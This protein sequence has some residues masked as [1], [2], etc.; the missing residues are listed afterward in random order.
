LKEPMLKNIL[1]SISSAFLLVLSFPQFDL[2]F[3]AWIAL[4]PLLAVLATSGPKR[5]F[6]F[7]LLCGIIFFSGIFHWILEVP[8]YRLLHHGILGLYLGFY[9]GLFGLAF[10]GVCVRLGLTTALIA[11][12]FFWV[13][14]EFLRSNLWFLALPWGLLAHSQHHHPVFIQTAS[15]TGT[16]GV[17]FLIVLVNSALTAVGDGVLSRFKNHATAFDRTPFPKARTWAVAIAGGIWIISLIYSQVMISRPFDGQAA[18]VAVVQPNIP[19]NKKWNRKYA[20]F[21]MQTYADLT[22]HAAAEQ[23][24]LIIWPESATPAAINQNMKVKRQV[25]HIVRSAETYLLL[26][27]CEQQ[28]FGQRRSK[29]IIYKNSAFLISAKNRPAKRQRY[30]KI[31]LLPFGEYLPL[32]KTIPWSMINVPDIE[33]SVPGNKYTVFEHPAFRFGVTIC[34][35]NIFPEMVRQYVLRGAE[36]IVNITNEAWFGKTAAP[37]QFVSMSVFRAVENR[38]YVARSA[39][40][41]ISCL[42]DPYGRIVDRVRN[43]RG[44]D[45]FVRGNLIGYV[46]PMTSKTFYTRYGDWPVWVCTVFSVVFILLALFKGSRFKGSEVQG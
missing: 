15:V 39:N 5:G 21:I 27:S 35:E 28:K 33:R 16:Y 31:R 2:S 42:I 3:L 26:G 1:F 41:G 13:S 4:T 19:Q 34:W 14:L 36:V 45:T 44:D 25:E 10:S 38:I 17:S 29:K 8:R 20:D 18:K 43:A 22:E 9:F 12:P 23:P 6:L 24:A 37:Y 46:I 32:K 7:S 40:T 30:Q 11:A